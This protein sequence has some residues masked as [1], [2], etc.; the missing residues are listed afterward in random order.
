MAFELGEKSIA[1]KVGAVTALYAAPAHFE[2]AHHPRS[3]E[4][5]GAFIHAGPPFLRGA[6]LDAGRIAKR[7]AIRKRG[8]EKNPVGAESVAKAPRVAGLTVQGHED[9]LKGAGKR[10]VR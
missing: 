10:E 3:I 1:E 5:I 9:S 4:G 8:E 7:A 2:V 6:T